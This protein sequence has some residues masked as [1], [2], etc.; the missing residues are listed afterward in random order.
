[1]DII[2]YMHTTTTIV[3]NLTVASVI[4]TTNYDFIQK[5]IFLQNNQKIDILC[6]KTNHHFERNFFS[7][8]TTVY[9]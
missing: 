9:S 7:T 2:L 8:S 4:C 5:I 1:M 6:I 3:K